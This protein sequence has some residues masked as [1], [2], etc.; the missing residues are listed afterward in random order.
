MVKHMF[1]Y[2]VSWS[3]SK[4]SKAI[5]ENQN[6]LKSLLIVKKIDKKA[7]KKEINKMLNAG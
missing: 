4:I 6:L 3:N 5:I 1:K 7:E 2:K